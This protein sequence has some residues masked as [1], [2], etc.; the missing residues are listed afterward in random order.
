MDYAFTQ[1]EK[2]PEVLG[3]A[4]EP[5][6]VMPF[7]D[8]ELAHRSAL[9]LARRA[10]TPGLL[11]CV[12]DARRSGF[13][14]VANAVF[15]RSVAPRFGYVAQDA[16][17]GRL[18][19]R[20]ALEAIEKRDGGLLGFN[21]GKWGGKLAGFGLASR[22]WAAANYEGDLFF[23]GYKSHYA[24]TEL[25]LI[26]M[27]QQKYRFEPLAVLIEVDWDKEAGTV[28][29][30]DRLLYYKRAQGHFDRK[31]TNPGLRRMFK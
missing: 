5:L 1:L 13:V 8:A 27:Q 17:A 15:R 30:D 14:A 28:H 25:T 19:L 18:W 26:A 20:L 4:D 16:F 31:V 23:P 24:D 29:P 21:D 9:Q 11:L 3:K 7:I 10:G 6:V 2:L 22:D 12:Q